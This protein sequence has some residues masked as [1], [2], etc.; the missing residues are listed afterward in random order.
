MDK[1]MNEAMWE[2]Y[3]DGEILDEVLKR[4]DVDT[5]PDL[6]NRIDDLLVH[7]W[8]KLNSKKQRSNK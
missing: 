1:K 8:H 5:M 4:L 2:D 3:S 6:F 7:S